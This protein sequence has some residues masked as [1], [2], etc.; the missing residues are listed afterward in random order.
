MFADFKQSTSQ[1][2]CKLDCAKSTRYIQRLQIQRLHSKK[3][4]SATLSD[5]FF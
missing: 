3:F 2:N 1:I 4:N 5:V